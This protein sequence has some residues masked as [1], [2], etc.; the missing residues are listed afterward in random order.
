MQGID[1][2]DSKFES[3][4]YNI[5]LICKDPLA[6]I[7]LPFAVIILLRGNKLCIFCR[8]KGSNNVSNF[9]SC[10]TSSVELQRGIELLLQLTN[11]DD[12]SSV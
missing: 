10:Q 8:H 2:A 4:F 5:T 12:D 9:I 1:F 3:N 11:G 7:C 6:S